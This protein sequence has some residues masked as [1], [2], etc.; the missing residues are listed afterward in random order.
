MYLYAKSFECVFL[1]EEWQSLLYTIYTHWRTSTCYVCSW[2]SAFAGSKSNAY[3]FFS[4]IKTQHI[5]QSFG[6]TDKFWNAYLFHTGLWRSRTRWARRLSEHRPNTPLHEGWVWYTT[7]GQQHV[8]ISL[9]LRLNP[10]APE[11]LSLFHVCLH[12]CRNVCIH[13]HVYTYVL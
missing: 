1:H 2:L 6:Q 5:P 8:T 7:R 9:L 10:H 3:V 12:A 13:V 11:P 4:S